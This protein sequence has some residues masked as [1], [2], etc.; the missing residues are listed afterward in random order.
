VRLR[1]LSA[2]LVLLVLAGCTPTAPVEEPPKALTSEQSERLAVARFRN[3][4]AGVRTI[5]ATLPSDSGEIRLEG[6]FDYA[7]GVGYAQVTVDS[8]AS[9]LVWWTHETIAIRSAPSEGA[10]LPWPEDGWESGAL[11][12]S[13]TTLANS[14]ALIASLGSDRPENPQ[15]LAQSDAAWLRADT[16]GEVEVDVFAGPS[17]DSVAT[18]SSD[19]STR[20]L[21]WVDATGL[22]LRFES[23][24]TPAPAQLTVDFGTADQ[25]EL[26]P[27]VP[28]AP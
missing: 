3:F 25:V 2:G 4:D 27:S 6:W 20:A 13:S 24:L 7:G 10:P 14:V 18:A 26:P 8:V 23:P 28:G 21:Y 19:L 5:D 15:L 12:P 9:G 22:L 11:D 16:V 17:A 1:A